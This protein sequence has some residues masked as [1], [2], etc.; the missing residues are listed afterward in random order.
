MQGHGL[1][2][3]IPLWGVLIAT[4]LLVLLSVEGGYQWARYKRRAE[5]EKEAPV[6]AMV[7]TML[8]FLAFLLAFT[9]S[10]AAARYHD[11]K[12]ALLHEANAIHLT[13]LQ[14]GLIPEPQRTE[15]RK[16]LRDYVEERLRW[17]GVV[18]APTGR[19]RDDLLDQLW[20]QA[21][22]VGA[23]NPGEVDVFLGSVGQVIDLHTERMM[24]RERSQIPTAF[25]VVLYL[26]A[27]L[28]LAAMGYHGGVAGTKRTPVSV[29]VAVA[30]SLVIMLVADLDRPGEGFVN[31][32]QQVMI[33]L[34]DWMA[35][36]KP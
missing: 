14:A 27:F 30:F 17:A 4:L 1:F 26:I 34:Q 19:S 18:K 32:S 31:V 15:V 2:A 35:Q 7:G 23:Q 6:G 12:V 16:I 24:L 5:V 36:S 29:A 3:A 21:A 28:A 33:D 22:V 13:Y 25:W 11:R 20:A 10:M 8:G 9:F